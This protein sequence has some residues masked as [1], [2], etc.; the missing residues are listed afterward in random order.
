[1]TWVSQKIF[2]QQQI[3]RRLINNIVVSMY[4]DGSTPTSF[5]KIYLGDSV[6]VEVHLYLTLPLCNLEFEISTPMFVQVR[7][8]NIILTF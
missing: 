3:K 2:L 1:M 6:L 4:S 5:F 8:E 7:Y